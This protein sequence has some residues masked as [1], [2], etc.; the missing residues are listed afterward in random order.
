MRVHY[1][2]TVRTSNGMYIQC[3]YIIYTTDLI[4][5]ICVFER[6]TDD[7]GFDIFVFQRR[8]GYNCGYNN[9]GAVSSYI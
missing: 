8:E 1:Y 5:V 7:G 3:V 2:Y 4:H 9:I 6:S